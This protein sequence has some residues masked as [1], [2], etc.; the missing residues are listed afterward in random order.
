MQ[1]SVQSGWPALSSWRTQPAAAAARD[2]PF[3][4]PEEVPVSGVIG[5]NPSGA[6]LED[7]IYGI[8]QA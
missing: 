8:L 7:I 1:Q 4:G 3:V 6:S 5:L 2:T